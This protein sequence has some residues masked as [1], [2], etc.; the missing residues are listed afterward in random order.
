MLS[1]FSPMEEKKQKSGGVCS[2]QTF[3][4]FRAV[5]RRNVLNI[6]FFNAVLEIVC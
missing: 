6:L 5:K 2:S 1:P 3:D 4:I